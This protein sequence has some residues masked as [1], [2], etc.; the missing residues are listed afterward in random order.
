[1]TVEKYF[2]TIFLKINVQINQRLLFVVLCCYQNP[3]I[4]HNC[5]KH[6]NPYLNHKRHLVTKQASVHHWQTGKFTS[7]P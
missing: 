5:L 6:T 1:M 3:N 2:Y 7:Y 4:S